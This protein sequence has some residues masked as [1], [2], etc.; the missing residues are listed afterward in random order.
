MKKII[1]GL[2]IVLAGGL[3]AC[4]DE[5]RE[6]LEADF[7]SDVQTVVVE[8]RIAFMDKSS[9]LPV[10]WNW[11]FEG[12]EPAASEL[13]SPEVTYRMPGTYAVKLVVGRGPEEAVVEKTEYVT[14][15]YP[16]EITVNFEADRLQATDA[17]LITLTDKSTGFPNAWAWELVS[18]TGEKVTSTEQNP[19]V[20]LAPGVYTVTLTASN[21]KSSGSLTETDYLTVIDRNAVTAAFTAS[22]RLT[23]E[24]GTVTFADAS[25]GNSMRQRWTFEDGTPA[26]S[27]EKNPAVTYTAAGK[28]K[29]TLVASNNE[30][31]SV[32]E[33][34]GYIVVVPGQSLV[35]LYPFA[36]N[37]DD[38]GPNGL[39]AVPVTRGASAVA[40]GADA[41][42]EGA[43]E[44]IFNSKNKDDYAF[45]EVPANP[46]LRFG[47]SDF[48]VAF[49]AKTSDTRNTQGVYQQ[50]SGPAA[51]PDNANRQSWFRFQPAKPFFRFVI[52]Y[53][54][55]SGN[56]TDYSAKTLADEEWHYYVCVHASGSTYVYVDGVKA[57]EALNKGLKE[58]DGAPYYI[59][60][61]YR[62]DEAGRS[63]ENFLH[64]S[65]S[66]YALYRRALTAVE[67]NALYEVLK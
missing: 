50:G 15:E 31:S 45:F 66:D 67:A 59:G 30:N 6:P 8:G 55:K 37:A 44:V 13:F 3:Y 62:G 33:T 49:W 12:G 22:T 63:F 58:I 38:A 65:L 43:G 18:R 10:R 4:K 57:A 2:L 17:D 25:I 35:V 20:R 29:V 48:T 24:G 42:R 47:S 11:Y 21:P 61:M 9:G 46:A 60:A 39:D 54:G 52:E 19:A 7:S 23:Y 32:K 34:E 36:G 27:S 53:T 1:Y 16:G 64:G 40:F 41:P 56:W 5:E 28:Y 51:R 26:V 14:I